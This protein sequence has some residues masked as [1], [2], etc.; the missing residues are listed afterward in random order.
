MPTPDL[1]L[2]GVHLASVLAALGVATAFAHFMQRAA[3]ALEA[4]AETLRTSAALTPDQ[5]DDK[6]AAALLARA[7]RL[8][9]AADGAALVLG[10]L[11][12]WIPRLAVG[13][14]MGAEASGSHASHTGDPTP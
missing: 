6:A 1:L 13:K 3:R 12:V 10:F 7:E 8:A 2:F 11:G 5:A 14:L 9:K 4:H